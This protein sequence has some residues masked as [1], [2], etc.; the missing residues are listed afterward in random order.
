MPINKNRA[1]WLLLLLVVLAFIRLASQNDLPRAKKDFRALAK[2]FAQR[3]FVCFSLN[4]RLVT[5]TDHR[6][7]AQLDDVQRAIRWIRANA[8]RYGVDPN[9]LGALGASAGGHLVALLG[10][11]VGLGPKME[12]LPAAQEF[13]QPTAKPM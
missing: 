13:G 9:R 1:P 2:G 4:Y 12:R 3:G 8:I 10:T 7:P 5:A 11:G 6:F